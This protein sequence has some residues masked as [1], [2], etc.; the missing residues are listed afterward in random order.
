[1]DKFIISGPNKLKGEIEVFGAK[2][3]ATPIL[4]ATLLTDNPCIIRNLPLIEDVFRMLELMK[5]LGAEIEWLSERDLKI[6][7][8]NISPDK[9]DE[10]IVNKLRSSIL[11]LGPLL[12]RFG[13]VV[14][15]EPGGC[16]I[17]SRPLDAH[18]E[19]VKQI[20]GTIEKISKKKYLFQLKKTQNREIVLPEFSVTATENIMISASLIPFKTTIKITALE[21]H[22]QDLAVVLNKMGA[23]VK[24]L[25]FHQ[26]EVQGKKKLAGFDH[27]IVYDS[28]EAGTYLILAGVTHSKI[29]VKNAFKNHL[30]LVLRKLTDFGMS[31]E[32]YKN[33]IIADGTKPLKAVSK[34]Q[35][36][37]YP[38]IPT[39]LQC[40]FG[41]LATQAQGA[42]MIHDPMY[43]GR[44]KYLEELNQMGGKVVLCDPHRALVF[45]KTSL[46][47][48]NIKTTDLRGGIALLSAA[49]IA[50]GKSTI[51]NVYQI[52]RGYEKIEK[53]L[54]K[55]GA[56]IKRVTD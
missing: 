36:M 7:C 51:E 13:K 42:T 15:P 19:A 32:I 27:K 55:L 10:D 39:D 38:G 49:L 30:D 4:A 47:G 21:P 2:N 6:T 14:M 43:E 8:K 24:I 56:D 54:E 18:F 46:F 41:V 26:I 11:F 45:G 33:K 44:F 5:K 20:G 37:P 31:F 9:L 3:A 28:V 12:V 52:D 16:L 35:T 22:V 1:M 23:E 25:P 29:T 34:I 48:K 53:R 40:Q 50:S 17:G